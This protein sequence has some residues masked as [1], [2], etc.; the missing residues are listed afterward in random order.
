MR[1]GV[2][3]L[4]YN[5]FYILLFV[6]IG[7]GLFAGR[8]WSYRLFWAGTAIYSLDSLAFLLSKSTRA[9]YLAGAGVTKEVGSLIDVGILDQ[10]VFLGSVVSLLSWWGFALY[11]Y[12]RRD[13]FR[14]YP[15][16]A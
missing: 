6:G 2:V 1:G 16:I 5:L 10:G 4:L 3:A 8:P 15:P 11:V 12:I 14:P 9:A 13:Y 7:V